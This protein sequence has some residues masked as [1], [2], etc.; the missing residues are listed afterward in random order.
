MFKKLRSIISKTDADYADIRY[1]IKRE[2][3]ISFNGKELGQI[4]SNTTDGYV[5][6]VLKNG[7][8]SSVAFT[9]ET[10]AEKALESASQNAHL[11]SKNIEKAVEF[12]KTKVIKDTFL[13][14]LKEDPRKVSIDE[15]LELT[16]KYNGIPLKHEGISTTAIQYL[17][18]IREKY[19]AST[20]GSEIRED[21]I[22]TRINGLITSKDGNLIQNVRAGVGGSNGFAILR[23][24]EGEFEKK[25]GIALDLL[26]ATPVKAGTYNVI[27]NPSMAG[28]FTHEAFGHFSEA[29]LIEDSPTMREKMQLGAKL[30]NNVLNIIDDPTMPDQLGFYRYDDEGV[31]ARPTQLLKEGVLVGRLHSRRTAAAFGEPLSGHCIAEDYRYAPIIRM[32]NI[33]IQPGTKTFDDLLVELGDGLYILDAKGGQTSGENF[34]FGAQ[35]AYLVKDGKLGEMIRDI[36]ITG[37]LYKTLQNITAVGD[38][39]VL[40]QIGGCGKGQLNI[41]SCNGAPHIL[42]KNII[43]GGV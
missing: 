12:A 14:K 22:T 30:G 31:R 39:L 29:D 23:N 21:L 9:K 38:D 3:K 28:V 42:V 24:K 27:L 34:T 15:K 20:E 6:R 32:G 4:G 25:T 19:F 17:E 16:R 7:G 8:I 18:V 5:I 11:I 37:N 2:T 43:I 41:R 10:D 40:C 33:F 36:N 35:Y 26:K 1:E 13:P